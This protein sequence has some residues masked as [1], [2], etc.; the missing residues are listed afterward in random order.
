MKSLSSQK[1]NG[2]KM[3]ALM[4]LLISSTRTEVAA[5][6]SPFIR[7]TRTT[8]PIS[9]NMHGHG[10]DTAVATGFIDS[11]LRGAAMRLHTRKQ[12]P[13]E[14][15]APEKP[16]EKPDAPRY[17]PTHQDYLN[18]LV[19]SQH[20][21]QAMEDIVNSRSDLA[22]FRNTGMERTKP[23]ETDI[24]FMCAEYNLERPEVGQAGLS[25]AE[26]LKRIT[27]NG[28]GK[29]VPEFVCHFYNHYFAHTAGGRMIG[30]QMSALLLDKKT[31]EFY[32]WDG[33]INKIKAA[34]KEV[35]EGMA[36]KWTQEEKDECVGATAATFRYGG[37]LNANLSGGSSPH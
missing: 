1:T 36:A 2:A 33:D 5:F 15:E 8:N 35:I 34:V 23:L 27:S 21:Y 26:E 3:A 13:K 19:D 18:F 31:L 32:K 7:H 24:Q 16:S 4:L 14:G 20:V 29:N 11:E 30:K 37:M 6:S 25:Y 17:V 10:G 12:A 28:E 22:M 9:L